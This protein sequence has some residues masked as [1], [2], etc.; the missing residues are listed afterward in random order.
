MADYQ[1]SPQQLAVLDWVKNGKGSLNLIAYAGTGK[2]STLM[3]VA[4]VIKGRAFMGAFNK[5]I[6]DEF[7]ARL[8][9]QQSFHVTGGTIH[10]AGMS[11]WRKVAPKVQVEGRKVM[12]IARRKY[13]WDRKLMAAICE[14]VGYAKQACLGVNGS[15]FS[16]PE[17]WHPI[18]FNYDI[19]DEIPAGITMERFIDRCIEVYEESLKQCEDCIDFDDMLLAPLYNKAPFTKYDWVLIDEAQDTNT[20]R[21]LLIPFLPML[22]ALL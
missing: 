16:V 15:S 18:I 1:L 19:Q 5:A 3:E 7:K 13:A 6:A 11:A 8:A 21:L 22:G 17:N 10:S 14:T 12:A 4:K 9:A 2:T 20:A